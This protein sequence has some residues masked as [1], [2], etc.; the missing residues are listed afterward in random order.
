MEPVELWLVEGGGEG[1]K[2]MGGDRTGNDGREEN[3]SKA[4]EVFEG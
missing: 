3:G 1:S 4:M 2:I